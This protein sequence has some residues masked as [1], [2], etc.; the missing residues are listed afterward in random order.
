MLPARTFK[1]RKRLLTLSAAKPRLKEEAVLKI[2]EL[3]ITENT[4]DTTSVLCKQ[5]L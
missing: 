1:M 5:V 3:L 4:G 2:Y